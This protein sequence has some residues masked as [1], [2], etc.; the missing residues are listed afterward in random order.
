MMSWAVPFGRLKVRLANA[1]TSAMN[2][3]VHSKS[4][5]LPNLSM[6]KIAGNAPRKFTKPNTTDAHRAARAEKPEDSKIDE[7]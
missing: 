3:N 7:L 4:L 1:I 5:R 6:V 2:G